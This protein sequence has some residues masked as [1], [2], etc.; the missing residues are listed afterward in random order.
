MQPAEDA[1]EIDTTNLRFLD[2]EAARLERRAHAAGLA[3][4]VWTVNDRSDMI[5]LLDLGADGIMTDET[6]LL[7]GV[8]LA[9]GQWHPARPDE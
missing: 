6:D 2:G 4:H 5:R 7:R 1:Q 9:R 8:L 3:V